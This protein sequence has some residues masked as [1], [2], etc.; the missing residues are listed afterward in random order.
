TR[1]LTIR[2]RVGRMETS[3]FRDLRAQMLASR[4]TLVKAF[5]KRDKDLTG[6][7]WNDALE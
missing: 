2:E 4:S 3:A 5:Q 6:M 7:D 1:K